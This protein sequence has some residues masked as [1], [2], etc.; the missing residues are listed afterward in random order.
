MID[1]LIN[2]GILEIMEEKVEKNLIE[3]SLVLDLENKKITGEINN[4]LKKIDFK[5]YSKEP[6]SAEQ[7]LEI[8]SHVETSEEIEPINKYSIW[9]CKEKRRKKA[10]K[11]QLMKK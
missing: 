9:L 11:P 6:M 2:I 10:K 5:K 4:E 7:L 1:F 8:D 3:S